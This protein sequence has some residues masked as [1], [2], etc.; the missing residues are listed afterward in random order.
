MPGASQC[1]LLFLL[2]DALNHETILVVDDR[3]LMR[4]Q[5]A[6]R[7]WIW[8][9]VM[10]RRSSVAVAV[11]VCVL[12]SLAIAEPFYSRYLAGGTC[13]QRF[14]EPAHLRAHP[15]QTISKFHVMAAKPDPLAKSHPNRFEV[16]FGFW[17]KNAGAYSARAVCRAEGNAAN[18]SVEADGGSFRIEPRGD[19][20]EVRLGSRLSVEGQKGFSP[21]IAKGDNRIMILPRKGKNEVCM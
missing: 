20:V 8:E 16:S 17:V 3:V 18:C 19:S 2:L 14:Y 21:N 7:R 5:S 12:P 1:G 15:Q 10:L 4:V 6:S 11:A 13:Y 9:I